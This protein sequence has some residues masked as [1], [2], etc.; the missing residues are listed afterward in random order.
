MSPH[1]ASD[2]LG[3]LLDLAGKT[4][5]ARGRGKLIEALGLRHDSKDSAQNA[6]NR[7]WE[8]LESDNPTAE[9]KLRKALKTCE[10]ATEDDGPPDLDRSIALISDA[11]EL[12]DI[13]AA[14]RPR[15]AGVDDEVT[16]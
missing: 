14:P 10:P 4:K 7:F 9:Q 12:L 13:G 15:D 2:S 11:L 1:E 6:W 5:A 8:V 16:P 3:A